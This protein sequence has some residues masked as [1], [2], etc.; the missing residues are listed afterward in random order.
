MRTGVT[1]AAP[2]AEGP[3]VP[4]S[5]RLAVP[6]PEG[7]GTTVPVLE[8]TVPELVEAG[9]DPDGLVV[10]PNPPVPVMVP[11]GARRVV[12]LVNVSTFNVP[13]CEPDAKNHSPNHQALA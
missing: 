9:P 10:E 1:V 11:V 2:L 5:V 7:P 13:P 8:L 3:P 4:G 6:L 12:F